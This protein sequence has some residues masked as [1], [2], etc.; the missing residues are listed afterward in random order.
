MEMSPERTA[1]GSGFCL[2]LLSGISKGGR[3]SRQ[4]LDIRVQAMDAGM[5]GC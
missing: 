3:A 5:R 1:S 2:M 4:Q